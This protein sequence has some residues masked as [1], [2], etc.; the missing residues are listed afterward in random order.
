MDQPLLGLRTAIYPVRDLA[1]SKTWW[2][3]IL[4]LEPY[5]DEPFYVGYSVGAFELGLLPGADPDDGVLVYWGVDDVARAIADSLG[6][7]AS[8]HVP[9]S[10]VGDGIVTGSVRTP[11]GSVLGFIFNPHFSAS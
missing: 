9:A 10:D 1:A 2:S 3:T 4:G 7:G 8:V 5:F 6:I 11:D